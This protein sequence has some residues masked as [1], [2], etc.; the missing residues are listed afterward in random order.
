[1]EGHFIELKDIWLWYKPITLYKKIY[2]WD[3]KEKKKQE[4][5]VDRYNGT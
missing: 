2:G 5:K 4:L 1:M 3:I